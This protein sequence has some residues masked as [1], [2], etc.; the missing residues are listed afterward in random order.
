MKTIL[1]VIGARPQIIKAAAISRAIKNHFSGE[2]KE[3]LLHTGQHYDA[4]MSQIFIDQ[5]GIPEPDI[6]LNAGSGSHGK[7]TAFMLEGIETELEKHQPDGVLVYG[8][9][10]STLA[11]A[12][13]ASK[14]H[15]PV[16]HV[17]A[18]LRSFNKRMPEEINRIG[19]DHVSTMLFSPTTT[20]IDNLKNENFPIST[21]APYS[22]DAPG[23][24][25]SGDVMYDNSLYFSEVSEQSSSIVSDL[26]LDSSEFILAT[27][28]RPANTDDKKRLETLLTSLLSIATEHKLKIVLPLHPRTKAKMER[29]FGEDGLLAELEKSPYF[30]LIPP[31]GFLD[32]I[33]LEKN[34][35]IVMTDSGGVQKEAFFFKKPCLVF[36]PQ[37]EW[38]EIITSGCARL[39]DADPDKILEAF[40]FF[41]KNEA[42]EFPSIFGDGKA[43]EFICDILVK[44]L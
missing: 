8:D 9:T 16:V 26:G 3:L 23:V 32:I 20:G 21:P 11:A 1:T 4:A 35:A 10:N 36:R 5:L 24:F 19:C 13:A 25:H 43:S 44:H 12:L 27:I 18:G 42:L 17:E 41:H 38:V 2:L 30:M 29:F 31:C 22:I 37:T 14:I 6:N 15:I 39:V 40:N 28:H 34:C 7:Q 33:A